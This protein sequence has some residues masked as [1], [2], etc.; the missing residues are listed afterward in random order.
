MS[1]ALVKC[2]FPDTFLSSIAIST[3]NETE[4]TPKRAAFEKRASPTLW[5]N[6]SR[7]SRPKTPSSETAST[8]SLARPRRKPFWKRALLIRTAPLLTVSRN[9]EWSIKRQRP[10]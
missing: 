3:E 5:K 4:F 7:V 10:F 1:L 2:T 9:D 6:L 8:K